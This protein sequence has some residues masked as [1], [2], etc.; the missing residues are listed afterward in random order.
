MSYD[1]VAVSAS[2]R[3]VLNSQP[4]PHIQGIWYLHKHVACRKYCLS[5]T[6]HYGVDS[7]CNGSMMC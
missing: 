2:N 4:E 5:H 6:I 3:R 1:R 7:R